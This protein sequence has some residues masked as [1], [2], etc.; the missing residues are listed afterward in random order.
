MET[1]NLNLNKPQKRLIISNP[2]SATWV[3]S[4]AGGKTWY[5]GY[6]LRNLANTMPRA[7]WAMVAQTFRKLTQ[8]TFA[9]VMGGLSALHLR[10]DGDFVFGRKPDRKWGWDTPFEP[11]LDYSHTLSFPSGFCL[12]L[13]SLEGNRGS[14]RGPNYDGIITDETLLIDEQKLKSDVM[15][16]KRGNRR[17]FKKHPMHSGVFHFTSMPYGSKGKWILKQGDYYLENYKYDF[18]SIRQKLVELQLNYVDCEDNKLRLELWPEIAALRKT[19]RFFKNKKGFIYQE[20]DIFDNLRNVGFNYILEQRAELPEFIF[21]VEI[22]NKRTDIVEGGF[23]PGLNPDTHFYTDDVYDDPLYSGGLDLKMVSSVKDS[24]LD[25]D[26]DRSKPLRLAVDWGGSVS[27]LSIA[28]IHD[29]EYRFINCQFVKHPKLINDL[30]DQFATYYKWHPTKKIEFIP[31]IAWGKKKQA[32]SIYTYNQKFIER[33]EYHGWTVYPVNMSIPADHQDRY[34]LWNR[35]LAEDDA[36][37]MKVRFNLV[38]CKYLIISMQMAPV[39]EGTD[40]RIKKDKSSERSKKIP[41]EEATHFSDTADQHLLSIDRSV[42]RTESAFVP[43]I[44]GSSR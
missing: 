21:L 44:Y 2:K 35:Y 10:V 32:D 31:D 12:S 34:L 20:S 38:K 24:R 6:F 18:K 1:E 9:S 13:I 39:T 28:Q 7:K 33:L 4:R 15:P 11:P 41:Q 22:L 17:H 3:A 8:D 37:L 36:E 43:N 42:I 26:I 27:V 23:Y 29:D 25:R 14:G 30:A 19:L 5:I 40:G 16:A